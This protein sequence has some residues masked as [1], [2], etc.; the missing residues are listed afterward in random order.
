MIIATLSINILTQSITALAGALIAGGFFYLG[1]QR[2]LMS[3]DAAE[4]GVT[5][6]DKAMERLEKRL[7]TV[8]GELKEAREAL[9]I[10]EE[11][12]RKIESELQVAREALRF[13]GMRVQDYERRLEKAAETRAKMAAEHN[14]SIVKLELELERTVNERNMQAARVQK[15]EQQV[16]DIY[17]RAPDLRDRRHRRREEGEF[18]DSEEET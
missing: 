18:H 15:L 8:E 17:A 7:E 1:P 12:L 10:T 11:R 3:R 2:K 4:K 14:E 6:L 5:A 16:K 13:S 9:K